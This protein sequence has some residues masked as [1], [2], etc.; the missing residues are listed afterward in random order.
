MPDFD[1]EAFGEIVKK[2]HTEQG[3]WFLNGFWEDGMKGEQAEKVWDIVHLFLE[4]QLDRKVRYGKRLDQYDEESDLEE[5]KAHRLLELMGEAQTV[6][7]LRKR[8]SALDIDNNHRMAVTEFLLDRF[9]KTPQQVI[10][11]PQGDVDPK[12]LQAAQDACDAAIAALGKAQDEAREAAAAAKASAEAAAEAAAAADASAQA[13]AASQQAAAEAAASKEVADAAAA[14]AEASA[15]EVRAA[16]AELQAA[17]DEITALEQA[18]ADKIAKFQAIIDSDASVVK[19]GS[20]KQQMETLLAED[21]LPLRKV[22]ITQQA[23]L[24]KLTNARK[25]AEEKEAAA[26]ARAAEAAKD[27]QAADDAADAAAKAKKAADEAAA[28]AAD[29]AAAAAKAQAEAEEAAQ[30]AEAAAAE[31]KAQLDEVAASST[32]PYGKLWW[33][34]RVMTEKKKF[35]Q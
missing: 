31:A 35:M 25:K 3:I 26:N 17:V 33:M 27:K 22:K 12:K 14:E 23:V 30:A 13:L 7:A 29:A 16:E 19:K 2:T 18:K 28:A 20:A 4:V 5:H 32:P 34:E 1:H 10:D 21:E 6:T 24:K 15:N 8:L 9:G 11:S